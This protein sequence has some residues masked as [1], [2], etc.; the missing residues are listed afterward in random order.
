MRDVDVGQE[1]VVTTDDRLVPCGRG[2]MHGTKLTKRV[3]VPDLQISRLGTVFQILRQLA[4]GAIRKEAVVLSNLGR[5][6]DR[7]MVL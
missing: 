3:I 5:P 1:I 6:H 7:H 4:D 2:P